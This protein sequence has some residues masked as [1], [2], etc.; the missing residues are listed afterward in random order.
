MLARDLN[1]A[2]Q[3]ADKHNRMAYTRDRLNRAFLAETNLQTLNPVR[4]ATARSY[5]YL[6]GMECQENG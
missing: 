5:T 6:K 3:D 4:D 2:I 1:A